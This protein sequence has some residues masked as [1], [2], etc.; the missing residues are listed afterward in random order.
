M[1]KACTINEFGSLNGQPSHVA[2]IFNH[3]FSASL[4]FG[5]TRFE[6]PLDWGKGECRRIM[7]APSMGIGFNEI[8]LMDSTRLVAKSKGPVYRMMFCFGD[9]MEWNE[10]YSGAEFQLMPFEGMLC[11]IEETEEIC[12]YGPER[13][14]RWVQI[15]IPPAKIDDI[16]SSFQINDEIFHYKHQ[17]IKLSRF[18]L[19]SESRMI[20]KQATR[21]HYKGA[22]KRMYLESKVTELL[23]VCL[24]ALTEKNPSRAKDI[25]L[26]RSD[27]ES[28]HR[29]KEILDNSISSSVSIKELARLV[30]LNESKLKSGFKHVFGRPVYSYLI[31]KR[32]EMAR[33]LLEDQHMRVKEVAELV[34]YSSSASFSKAFNKIYGFN[35]SDYSNGVP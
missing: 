8:S 28:L 7:L 26:S 1:K 2:D 22:I 5:E 25:K 16:L 27:L 35:P 29:A 34:G 9:N 11:Q 19:P 23:A 10:M 3:V 31:N 18:K 32:M 17:N 20:I 30:F 21:C 24:Y 33:I 15:L 13:N 12:P 14:Y 6:I 4:E